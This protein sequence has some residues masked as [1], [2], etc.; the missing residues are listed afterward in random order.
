MIA[1]LPPKPAS[2]RRGK[3]KMP[4][5]RLYHDVLN[6]PKVQRLPARLFRTWVNLLCLASENG[7][8]GTLPAP[9][10][11]AFGM[12]TS[13]EK[14]NIDLERL[15]EAGLIDR[16]GDE[17]RMRDWNLWQYES[18]SSTGRVREY[19]AHKNETPMKRSGNDGVTPPDTEA[20]TEA[21]PE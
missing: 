5:F 17:L 8:R 20:D 3:A 10:D 6:N 14:A 11:L 2:D 18:D 21:E 7:E 13:A 9:E 16:D 1:T 12:R 15:I 4:W 19:R